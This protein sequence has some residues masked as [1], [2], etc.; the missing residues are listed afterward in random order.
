[1]REQDHESAQ[2]SALSF[3][4]KVPE[5]LIAAV[6]LPKVANRQQS[7]AQ[8]SML[9]ALAVASDRD[10]VWTSYSRSRDFYAA[11]GRYEGTDYTY[12]T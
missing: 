5:D 12:A 2:A 11:A 1:M 3:V 8:A 7:R 6:G 4:F 10:N 9:A